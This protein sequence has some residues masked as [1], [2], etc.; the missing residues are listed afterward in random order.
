MSTVFPLS[1]Y[2]EFDSIDHPDN[3]TVIKILAVY[4]LQNKKKLEQEERNRLNNSVLKTLGLGIHK[5]NR[6]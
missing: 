4:K 6:R 1:K 3:E 2:V 5:P